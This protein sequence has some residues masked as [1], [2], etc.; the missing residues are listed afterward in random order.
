MTAPLDIA[1]VAA[2]TGFAPSALRYYEQLGLITPAGR[3]GLRRTY[4]PAVLDRLALVRAARLTGFSLAELAELLAAAPNEVR[5]R[6]SEKVDEIDAQM[7]ALAAARS[8]LGHA[9]TCEHDSILDCPTFIEGLRS[10]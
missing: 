4:D 6:L 7:E 5:S 9:L 2:S 3:S 10:I 1:D 8:M